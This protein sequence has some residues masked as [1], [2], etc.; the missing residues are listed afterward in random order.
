MDPAALP[1]PNIRG[2]VYMGDF[3]ARHPALGDPSRFV[4]RNETRLLE[5]IRRNSLTRWN[6]AGATHAQGGALDHILACGLVAS[7]VK[8]SSVP[9]LFSD[10]MVLSVQHSLPATFSQ[11]HTRTRIAIPPKYRPTYISY[12]TNHLPTFDLHCSEKLYSWLVTATHAFYTRYVSKPH[13]RR[14]PDAPNWTMDARI[15]RAE[16]KATEAGLDFQQQSTPDTL[17]QYQ[18]SRDDLDALQRCVQTD[19]WHKLTDSI[20]HQTSVSSMWHLHH[21]LAQYAQDLDEWSAQSRVTN[22]PANIQNALSARENFRALRLTSALLDRDE[23]DD[24]AITNNELQRALAR[25]KAIS[26]GDDGITYAVLRALL[27]VP[28]N[29][30]PRLYNL[31]FRLGYVPR[32]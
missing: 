20:N 25:G 4:N 17:H 27:T 6:I 32:A 8:C 24:V 13:L 21:N 11:M 26:P 5:Y 22:L 23:E 31:C 3:N 12:M 16:R 9:A 10:H 7:Q 1:V 19:S 29:P 30:L 15:A 18:S 14:R 2:M 28:G